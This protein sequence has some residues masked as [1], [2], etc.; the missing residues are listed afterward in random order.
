MSV[1]NAGIALIMERKYY[2]INNE[3]KE[4]FECVDAA[5]GSVYEFNNS[6]VNFVCLSGICQDMLITEKVDSKKKYEYCDFK[7]LGTMAASNGNIMSLEKFMSEYKKSIGNYYVFDGKNTFCLIKDKNILNAI[8]RSKQNDYSEKVLEIYNGV[9]KSIVCQDEQIQLLLGSLLKNQRLADSSLNK[10]MIVKLKE[11][12]LVSGGSGVGKTETLRIISKFI[13]VP[14]LDIEATSISKDGFN[15]MSIE[16]MLMDLYLKSGKNIELAQRGILVIDGLDKLMEN[17]HDA[18]IRT[19]TNISIQRELT[20][21]LEGK[22]YYIGENVAFDTSKLSVVGIGRF[23]E[24]VS[25]HN[26]KTI[27]NEIVRN[28]GYL[29]EFINN[30]SNF[31]HYNSLFSRELRSILIDSDLSPINLY[32]K[33]FESMGIKFNYD[34]GFIQYVCQQTIHLNNGARGLKIVID[35]I[36]NEIMFE[37]FAGECLEVDLTMPLGNSKAYRLVRRTDNR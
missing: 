20:C 2:T 10:N 14:V 15:G 37:I 7:T 16:D 25:N 8:E 36:M 24:V 26:Y 31:V 6:G 30:F 12:I 21:L 34:D 18:R 11:N 13:D 9:K 33:L 5:Y 28:Y 19:G 22:T 29:P 4:Y 32:K 35:E 23:N 27:I 1:Y 3:K 17:D